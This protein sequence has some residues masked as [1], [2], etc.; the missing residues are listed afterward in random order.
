[1]MQKKYVRKEEGGAAGVLENK[2]SFTQLLL[3]QGVS[4]RGLTFSFEFYS[5]ADDS[6]LLKKHSVFSVPG[7]HSVSFMF[8]SLF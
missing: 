1:M 2:K 3:D 8:F 7:A 5:A 6:S 4:G